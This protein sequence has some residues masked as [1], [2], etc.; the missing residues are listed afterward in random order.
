MNMIL[1]PPVPAIYASPQLSISGTTPTVEVGLT[2]SRAD[3]ELTYSQGDAGSNIQYSFAH[4]YG[5]S[6]VVFETFTTT[7]STQKA[8]KFDYYSSEP[9]S[10]IIQGTNSH[11]GGG[12]KF[13]SYGKASGNPIDAGTLTS[14]TLQQCTVFPY[15]YGKVP[16]SVDETNGNWV[17]WITGCT[18]FPAGPSYQRVRE[19]KVAGNPVQ[20]SFNTTTLEKGWAALPFSAGKQSLLQYKTWYDTLQKDINTEPLPGNPLWSNAPGSTSLFTQSTVAS[21]NING[22]LHT[23]TL[24]LFTYGTQQD[25]PIE[26]KL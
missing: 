23:Y 13:D 19:S 10:F 3:F 25:N 24:Y 26:F 7:N 20:F 4:D 12:Q 17:G 1:F 18:S 5:G 22:I 21:V 11:L 16:N 15:F 9:I 2:F 14:T 6:L 8:T